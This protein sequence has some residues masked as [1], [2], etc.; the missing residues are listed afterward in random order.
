MVAKLNPGTRHCAPS[1]QRL[2]TQRYRPGLACL[3]L[4]TRIHFT[5]KINELYVIE[6]IGNFISI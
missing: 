1:G 4:Q 3:E 5:N 6:F 2:L